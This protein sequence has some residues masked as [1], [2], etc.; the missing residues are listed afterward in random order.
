MKSSQR[1]LMILA[2][3]IG[4]TSIAIFIF[5][6]TN[7]SSIALSEQWIVTDVVDGNTLT[8]RQTDGSQMQVQLCGIDVLEVKQ[9]KA[10]GQP[11]ANEAK[12]KLQSL[13]AAADS[14]VIIIPVQKNSEGRTVAEVMAH[15]KDDMEIS[16]QEEILKSG[17]AKIHES[18]IKC[19]NHS[20]FEQAQK[21]AIASKAGIWKQ[22]N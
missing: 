22:S 7:N 1:I 9:D 21:L 11:L 14:Q 5:Q 13:V 12:Q 18:G 10:L 20:A 6:T 15:G 17:L 19:P 16:F 8:V 3:L 4:T 2:A